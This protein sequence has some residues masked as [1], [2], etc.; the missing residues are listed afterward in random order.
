ME[1]KI[2]AIITKHL[3]FV[4]VNA[5]IDVLNNIRC[6]I[7]IRRNFGQSFTDYCIKNPEIEQEYNYITKKIIELKS[8]LIAD[9]Q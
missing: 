6:A 9:K 5:V 4:S 3:K 8:A 2:D 7:I 1:Q